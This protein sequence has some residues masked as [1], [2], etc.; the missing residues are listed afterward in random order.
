MICAWKS[1]ARGRARFDDVIRWSHAGRASPPMWQPRHAENASR[2]KA[3][4]LRSNAKRNRS[5]SITRYVAIVSCAHARGQKKRA[6]RIGAAAR[7][8]KDHRAD[9]PATGMTVGEP[10]ET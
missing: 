4:R 5:S 6:P 10:A 7:L 2:L 9:R 8:G 3:K 1:I